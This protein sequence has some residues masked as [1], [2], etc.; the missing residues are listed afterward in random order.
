MP[1]ITPEIL[2][3]FSLL[4]SVVGYIPYFI[5]ILS[6]KTK[7]HAFSWLIWAILM[8]IAFFAQDAGGAGSGA[9]ATGFSAVV[10]FIIVAFALFKGEK[11]ITRSDWITF[12]AALSAIPIWYVTKDPLY[13]VILITVI[14]ALGFYPTFRKSWNKPQEELPLPWGLN[15][16]KFL[17]ALFAL[18]CFNW[19]TAL[20][21][22]SLV[23]M[24]GTFFVMIIWR[25]RIFT[26]NHSNPGTP[27]KNE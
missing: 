26:S 18:E 2:G 7:P 19:T 16:F 24:N 20:Y 10:A 12:I 23:L 27:L 8:T 9:W 6:G 14:D 17:V 1:H 5:T 25:K 13:S 21:P 15:S 4:I 3:W 22:A 11:Q